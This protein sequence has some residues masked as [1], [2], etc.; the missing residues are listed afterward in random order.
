MTPKCF[1]GIILEIACFLNDF[2]NRK[3]VLIL[4]L[5]ISKA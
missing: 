5:I 3:K 2:Q 1:F 4:F